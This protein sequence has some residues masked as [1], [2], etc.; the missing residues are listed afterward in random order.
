VKRLMLAVGM[1]LLV[2]STPAR[3]QSTV[4][5][6]VVP[7][8]KNAP[9]LTLTPDDIQEYIGDYKLS[10]GTTL[11]L[12]RQGGKLYGQINAMPKRE[13]KATGLRK[14]NAVDGKLSV[15]IKYTWDGQ[16]TGNVAYV[17]DSRSTA[18]APVFVQ[19]ASR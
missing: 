5:T 19:F 16:V 2:L 7:A 14:F 13:L 11:L 3:S 17:D 9:V 10:N 15:H 8:Q 12:T 1:G 18:L 6:V 4:E